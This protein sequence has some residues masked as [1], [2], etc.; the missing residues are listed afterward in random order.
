MIINDTEI[1]DPHRI[2]NLVDNAMEYLPHLSNKFRALA[3]DVSIPNVD[4]YDMQFADMTELP[5][6]GDSVVGYRFYRIDK[7]GDRYSG[8]F[9]Q[10]I[11][12]GDTETAEEEGIHFWFSELL[13]KTYLLS[14][15]KNDIMNHN[16]GEFDYVLNRVKGVYKGVSPDEGFLMSEIDQQGYKEVL[17]VTKNDI[18]N[19]KRLD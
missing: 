4:A 14:Q 3:D 13:A 11:P 2:K 5:K 15:L 1:V 17:R 6:P 12:A 9:N 8:I 16:E 10:Y 19:I 7:D 18:E